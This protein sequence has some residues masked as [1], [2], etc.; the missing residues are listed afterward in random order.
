MLC[1]ISALCYLLWSIEVSVLL[2]CL[3]VTMAGT[4]SVVVP[5]VVL[6]PACTLLALIASLVL[7]VSVSIV[8]LTCFRCVTSWVVGPACGLVLRMLVMLER[9]ISRLVLISIVI[10][11]VRPLP[12]LMWSL[13][14]VIELPLPMTGIALSL[15]SVCSAPPVPMKWCWPR[16]LLCVSSIR[17]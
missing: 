5:V 15:S 13:L 3:S 7:L 8:L 14:I 2:L 17:V 12:L 9:T 1:L 6:S 16:R 10:R 11:V 4:L